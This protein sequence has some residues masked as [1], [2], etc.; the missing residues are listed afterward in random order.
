M[1]R[2]NESFLN[3]DWI[4]TTTTYQ[5]LN[6]SLNETDCQ[7]EHAPTLSKS[8]VIRTMVLS[9]MAFASLMGN[10]ATIWNIYQK[11]LSRRLYRHNCSAIYTLILHLSISDIL[12]TGFC[13]FGEAAWS[14]TVEWLAGNLMCKAFKFFQMFSLYLSTYVLVLIGIDRWVAVRYPMKSLNTKKRCNRLLVGAYVFSLILSIPQCL[15]FR[16]AQGPFIEEFSQCVTHGFYT[17]VW[18]E[19]LYTTFTLIFMFIIPLAVIISSYLSTFRTIAGKY[20]WSTV[21][22]SEPN[23]KKK[24]KKIKHQSFSI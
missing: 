24:K 20:N 22:F 21:R 3:C 19:Q 9:V 17:A 12:V 11:R 14:Y 4:T 7:L 13:L 18:Q 1:N 8:A 5:K 23:I 2:S 10:I 16:V 15:I 6:L